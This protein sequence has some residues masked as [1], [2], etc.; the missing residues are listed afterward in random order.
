MAT[1]TPPSQPASDASASNEGEGNKTADRNYREATQK[2]V[3]SERGQQK[4]RG[5]GHLSA[6]EERDVQAAE[7]K[8]KAHAKEHDPEETRD[9]SKPS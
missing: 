8:A 4:I 7:A 3:N 2:F 9:E 5:A 6:D 1:K